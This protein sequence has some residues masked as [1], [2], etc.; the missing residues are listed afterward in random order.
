MARRRFCS[1]SGDGPFL[2][3]RTSRRPKAGQ[4]DGV[5][6]EVERDLDRATGRRPSPARRGRV[7]QRAH[8]GGGEVAG[9]A[10]DAKASPGWG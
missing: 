10:G 8:A 1:H 2:T 3:P 5:V 4:S 9:D 7:D 6:A